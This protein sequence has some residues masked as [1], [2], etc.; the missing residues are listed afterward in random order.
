MLTGSGR[1]RGRTGALLGVLLLALT[2][3]GGDENAKEQPEGDGPAPVALTIAPE[4]GAQDVP[5]QGELAVTAEGGTLTGV[6]VAG[7]EG[8]EVP[9]ALTEEADAWAPDEALA[10]DTEYSV[11]A[12]GENAEGDEETSTATFTTVAADATF[13]SYWNIPDGS[14]VGVGMELS[15]TFDTPIQNTAEVGEA[16]RITTDP[17]VEVRGHWFGDQRID[18]RP[19]EY[20]EPGTE[21]EIGFRLRGVEGADGVFGTLRENVSFTVGR[22]QVST[23]DAAAHTMTV[24]RDGEE[25]RTIP[26]T[27]GAPGNE[28]WNGKMVITEKHKETRMD[29]ATVGFGGEYDIPDVPH[30]MRLSTSGTFIHGNYWASSGTFGSANVSHGCVGLGD[31]QGAGDPGTQGAWFYENSMIGDVVEVINSDD[32][33]IAPDNGINGWNMDWAE[34]GAGQ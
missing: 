24:T 8:E 32:D 3:C 16:V 11:T 30:A 21:V 22:G 34:W 2:A 26:I 15:V 27:A 29:G 5:T 1:R 20:W 25:I 10:N 23:V 13:S 17:P 31:A 7:P 18:F 9:G 12:V 19:E 28:T 6:T 33:V 4:D 14:E